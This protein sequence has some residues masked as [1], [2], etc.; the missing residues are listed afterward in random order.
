MSPFDERI[1][2]DHNATTPLRPEVVDAMVSVLRDGHGNPS[3][4]H[5][6]GAA[7][8]RVIDQA[9]DQVAACLGAKP[10]EVVFTGSA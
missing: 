9:R 7:A 3:S 2:L 8:R 6:E 10:R 5:R 4:T 1:Y